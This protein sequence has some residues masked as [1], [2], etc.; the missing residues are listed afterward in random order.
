MKKLLIASAIA[1][2]GCQ[3]QIDIDGQ[4]DVIS[5]S[6]ARNCYA[7]SDECR[8]TISGA[9]NEVFT[10]VPHEGWQFAGWDYCQ[11]QTG[12]VCRFDVLA[13]TVQKFWGETVPALTAHFVPKEISVE[14]LRGPIVY[15]TTTELLPYDRHCAPIIGNVMAVRTTADSLNV[16]GYTNVTF[17]GDYSTLPNDNWVFSGTKVFTNAN[18]I[19]NAAKI[20][21]R[22]VVTITVSGPDVLYSRSVTMEVL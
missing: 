8:G 22:V 14:T 2:A 16:S 13:T 11:Y 21:G 12:S 20:D 15:C 3:A 6:G 1:L 5:Q 7:S 17:T 9:F 18:W 4:G 10:A 19:V